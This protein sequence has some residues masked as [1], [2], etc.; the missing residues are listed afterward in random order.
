MKIRIKKRTKQILFPLWLVL[1]PTVI[2]I[3]ISIIIVIASE[4]VG[5]EW[6][7]TTVVNN[8]L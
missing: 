5:L 7:N 4:M 8:T 2:M 1:W 6:I 3:F